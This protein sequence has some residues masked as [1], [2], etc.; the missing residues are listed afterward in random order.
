[1]Q[2]GRRAARSDR[3]GSRARS[4][5]RPP[6]RRAARGQAEVRGGQRAEIGHRV[7]QRT[8]RQAA[9]QIARR[10]THAAATYADEA[11]S[12][13]VLT[14][15]SRRT[16]ARCLL[17]GLRVGIRRR[18]RREQ[19]L[20]RAHARDVDRGLD[21][22]ALEHAVVARR[23][24]VTLP[25]TRPAGSSRRGRWSR[26]RRRPRPCA[27]GLASA[28]RATRSCTRT[29]P[30]RPRPVSMPRPPVRG[31][32]TSIDDAGSLISVRRRSRRR[33]CRC[34]RPG[35]SPAIT[36]MPARDLAL[37]AI[38]PQAQHAE[39][40]RQRRADHAR[41][42]RVGRRRALDDREILERL[43]VERAARHR[44]RAACAAARSRRA[45]RGSRP[46]RRRA[47]RS[48]ATCRRC[49]RRP[50]TRRP[51]AAR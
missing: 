17:L 12:V 18:R 44:A 41:A 43:D 1:M 5:R 32:T 38:D 19:H 34:G 33:P 40:R 7:V 11:R 4:S 29:S 14:A 9:R 15:A 46:R 47:R 48:G 37:A 45:A 49:P 25:T 13:A 3:R 21:L 22:D 30:A 50:T 2:P 10:A 24:C 42:E 51:R 28:A 26:P 31:I 23:P 36:G 20:D 39:V 27:V 16:P 8:P 6:A 35:R